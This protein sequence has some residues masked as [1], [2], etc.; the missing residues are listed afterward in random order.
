M[1][2]VELA[3]AHGGAAATVSRTGRKQARGRGKRAGEF[4]YLD[5]KLRDG[6]KTAGA[7]QNGHAA[8]AP[9]SNQRGG[10]G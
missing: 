1:A 8:A 6:S 2:G 4:L 9:S 5:A 7:R 10:G 3:A